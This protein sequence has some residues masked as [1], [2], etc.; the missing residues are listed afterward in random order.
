MALSKNEKE[1]AQERFGIEAR[2]AKAAADKVAAL[3]AEIVQAR[4]AATA[5]QARAE[6]AKTHPA[7]IDALTPATATSDSQAAADKQGGGS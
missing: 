7:L 2:R 3:E 5:A 4:I 6:H 1:K